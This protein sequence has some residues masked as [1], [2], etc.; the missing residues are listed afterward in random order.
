MM[1]F[2]IHVEGIVRPIVG[3]EHRKLKMREEL[4]Q[5][6]VTAHNEAMDDAKDDPVAFA[7]ERLGDPDTLR[8]ELQSTVPSIEQREYGGL[9]GLFFEQMNALFELSNESPAKLSFKATL[10]QV[11]VFIVFL[12]PLAL[13]A[14]VGI[15]LIRDGSIV[16]EALTKLSGSLLLIVAC[17]SVSFF[18]INYFFRKCG[19]HKAVHRTSHLPSLVIAFI[20]T[21]FAMAIVGFFLFSFVAI[22]EQW[23]LTRIHLMSAEI[24]VIL[25]KEPI[26]YLLGAIFT[27][28]VAV[29]I[30]K[31]RRHYNEWGC[32]DIDE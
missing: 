16:W 19:L 1:K 7:I 29:A 14:C 10:S 15:M 12:L 31:E 11:L 4:M 32:L 21:L 27:S 20:G 3:A 28:F 5:H 9:I 22:T 2:K 26:F 24:L 18:S 25:A 23:P 17:M 8:E 6:L 13:A 30:H